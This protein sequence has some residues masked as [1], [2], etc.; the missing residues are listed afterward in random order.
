[1]KTSTTKSSG[2]NTKLSK[3][4]ANNMVLTKEEKNSII[5]ILNEHKYRE[6]K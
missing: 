6:T 4:A 1:M 5:N 3:E 2:L